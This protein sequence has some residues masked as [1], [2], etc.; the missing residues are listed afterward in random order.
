MWLRLVVLAAALV[1][2]SGAG[3][4]TTLAGTECPV[5]RPNHHSPPHG[6]EALP[7][8]FAPLWYGNSSVGTALWPEGQVIVRPGGP[9]AVLDDGALRM[10]F[11]WVKRPGLRLQISGARV[12]DSSVVL[13]VQANDEF[14]AQGIQPSYLIFPTPG[15]WR[16]TAKAGAETLSFVTAVVKMG[17]GAGDSARSPR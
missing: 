15:C 4:A 17:D 12:D 2:A 14:T 11:L 13:R 1:S 5:T 16:V 3:L 7:P 9:G 8:G 6:S 10:K